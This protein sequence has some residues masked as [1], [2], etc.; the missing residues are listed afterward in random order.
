VIEESPVAQQPSSDDEGVLGDAVEKTVDCNGQQD[1]GALPRGGK[2][3]Q[4]DPVRVG[5]VGC[6]YQGRLLAQAVIRTSDLRVVACAD[7]VTEAA[8]AVA[9]LANQAEVYASAEE[10]LDQSDVDAVM[11]ATPNHFLCEIALTAIDAGKHVLAEKPI[12]TNEREAA[13]IEAAA[14]HSGI[15][16][17][18]GYSLRFFVAQRRVYDLLA[19]GAVG[20]IQAVT[21]GIGQGPLGDWFAVPEMGGGALL[22]LGSHLVDEVLWFV[23]DESVQVTADV[24]R[25][26]D[27]GSDETS[28]FQVRFAGGAVAQC[29]VTQAAEGWFDFVQIYGRQ[30]RIGLASSNWLQYEISVHSSAL[31]AY[32]EPTTIRPRLW[33]DPIMMMLVP[34]VQEFAAAIR[35]NRQPAITAADGRQV[36]KILDAVVESGR[37]GRSVRVG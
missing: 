20:E 8:A 7:P 13:R 37:T 27:A 32:A 9:A 3:D 4:R 31:P 17:M 6:G 5:I 18:A 12:A 10:L 25:R 34:E 28:A 11:I 21:A 22:Y 23:G 2:M 30:G 36:L 19:A 24:R 15:C 29:L 14:V 35:E 26:P 16:Y 1:G 33:G